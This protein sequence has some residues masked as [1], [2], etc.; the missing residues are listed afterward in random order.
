[1]TQIESKP[2]ESATDPMR[3]S[4]GPMAAAPPGQV[5]ELI[6]RPNFTGIAAFCARGTRRASRTRRHEQG[7]SPVTAGETRRIGRRYEIEQ[8][9]GRGGMATVHR[10][11][12][13]QLERR[14]RTPLL[15]AA[16]VMLLAIIG[17]AGGRLLG[18]G[19]ETGGV[20]VGEP[21]GEVFGSTPEP[22]EEPTQ[23]PTAEPTESPTPEP[24]ARATPA[25]VA[26]ATPI[27]ATPVPP[28]A[29]PAPTP[30]AVAMAVTPDQTVATWY[31]Y[32]ESGQFD[33]AYALWSDRMRA[34]FPRE[35]NLD[36]RWGD[37]ADVAIQQ[38]SVTQQSSST[39]NV[40]IDF[41]ETKDNGSSRRFVGSWD[42]VRAG[43]HWLLD[44]PNF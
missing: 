38:I 33:A 9:L 3:P 16:A 4:V 5:N 6:W 12:D 34:N 13:A 18:G 30:I 17:F 42:L 7:F 24:T 35:G 8:I 15:L 21:R 2:T 20:I 40:F 23:R 39:A 14:R 25:P 26:V 22:T 1:M 43:D 32:V 44:N 11:R 37:T 41:V 31:S 19:D 28:R 29:T 36:N 10:A 27:P